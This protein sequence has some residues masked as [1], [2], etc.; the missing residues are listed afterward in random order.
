MSD[1]PTVQKLADKFSAISKSVWTSFWFLAPATRPRRS[2]CLLLTWQGN[3]Y[4]SCQ[5]LTLKMTLV[6]GGP[7]IGHSVCRGQ[8]NVFG[9]R[10]AISGVEG[11]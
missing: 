2:Q 7:K 9:G 3:S 8:L 6:H 1:Y 11:S 4:S 5:L 10:G